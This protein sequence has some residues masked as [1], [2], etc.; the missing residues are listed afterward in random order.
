MMK[1]LLRYVELKVSR[2]YPGDDVYRQLV[3]KVWCIEIWDGGGDLVV[4]RK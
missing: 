1:S 2:G 3:I 4:T